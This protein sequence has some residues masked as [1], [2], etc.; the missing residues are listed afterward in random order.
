MYILM[1][2]PETAGTSFRGLLGNV[3]GPQ[4]VF[5]GSQYQSLGVAAEAFKSLS[6]SEQCQTSLFT[7]P[8]EFGLHQR[9]SGNNRYI[10]L[11]HNPVDRVAYVYSVMKAERNSGSLWRRS[12]SLRE[13]V[14]TASTPEIDNGLVRQ[15]AGNCA[16]VPIGQVTEAHLELAKA[17]LR[18]H[19][20]AFGLW[21]DFTESLVYVGRRLD[22]DGVPLFRKKALTSELA[23]T[24]P[25]SSADR[26]VIEKRCRLDIEL[27][28]Y[29]RQLYKAEIA[30]LGS[31]F[32]D[33]VRAYD[34]ALRDLDRIICVEREDWKKKNSKFWQMTRKPAAAIGRVRKM[35][36]IR[37]R[38]QAVA[39][40]FTQH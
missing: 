39:R 32:A 11:F 27:Y 36:G 38:L 20:E 7:S 6:A 8:L 12:Q 31:G 9:L 22:W 21:E 35:L 30:D 23:A 29:A 24:V 15:V 18:E 1:D 10:T 3:Y 17:N 5:V 16:G 25:I 33:E 13:F 4:G 34:G 14:E 37:T 2:L 26:A 28:N 19:F 40:V